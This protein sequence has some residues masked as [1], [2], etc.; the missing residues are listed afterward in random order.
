[1]ERS[2]HCRALLVYPRFSPD[3][4]WNYHETCAVV[5][6][7]YSAAPLGL[8]TVAALLP[9]EW[10]LRLVDCNVESLREEDLAW[11]DL[12]LT[13]GML[14]QQRGAMEVVQA[15]HRHGKPVVVGGPDVTC[16]PDL[17]EEAEFRVIGEAEEILGEFCDAWSGGMKRGVFKA[18]G[19]PDITRSPVPRFDLLKLRHYMHVG[20]QRSRGCPF[21]CEFCNVI[22]LNGRRPR[23]KTNAQMLHELDTLAGLGYRGHVDF[24]DDNLIGDLRSV[25]PFLKELGSW[26]EA[27]GN[28]FEFS[29][30]VSI[31]LADNPELLTLMQKANFFAVFVGVETPDAETLC[32]TNKKQ[33]TRSDIVE[34]IHR[35][36]RAGMFVNAGFILGFDGER[37]SV[38][39]DMIRCIEETSIPVCMV[40]LLYALPNTQLSR[41]LHAEGR[42]RAGSDRLPGVDDADQCS[43]GLN[44]ETDRPRREILEDYRKLIENIYSPAAFFARVR[45]VAREI[46][47]SRNSYSA[48]LRR[49][50]KDVRSLSRILWRLAVRDRATRGPFQKA[51][52]DA[53]IHNPSALRTVVSMA[54][55]YLHYGAFARRM[56]S[57]L[58]A[59]IEALPALPCP[60]PVTCQAL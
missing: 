25:G 49:T 58:Q 2:S 44:F 20:V 17:Y 30:E 10:S 43:S 52:L 47:V 37:S 3:S 23:S 13:G 59:Q 9:A 55:L 33:N 7:R 21:N 42:L 45:R 35:F 11:A 22:E 40:G 24:V 34:S 38:G 48:S 39:S 57:R 46:D 16:S 31:N 29:T 53:L 27:R 28:P 51:L 4:F 18:G 54:A 56:D 12:V 50:A 32:R 14:P 15:A 5:G 1:M 8:I 6:A 19:F 36:Y 41:R 26:L 60:E